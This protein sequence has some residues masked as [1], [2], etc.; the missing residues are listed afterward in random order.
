MFNL[1]A[2]FL[3]EVSHS[4]LGILGVFI[5]WG[6]WLELRLPEPENRIPGRLW[7]VYMVLMGASLLTY[8]EA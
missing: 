7:A 4:P 2:E 3:A 6:R 5:G 1:R 8:R